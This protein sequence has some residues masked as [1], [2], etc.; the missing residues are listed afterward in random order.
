MKLFKKITAALCAAAMTTALIPTT[1]LPAVAADTMTK[2]EILEKMGIGWNLGNT[3]D[4]SD[5]TWLSNE[6]DYETAWLINDESEK[7]LKRTSKELIKFVHE[8]GFSSIRIPVSWHNHMSGSDYTIN[9]KWMARVHEVVDLAIDEGMFVII[10]IHHDNTKNSN[11]KFFYPS[12]EYRTQSLNYVGDVW[13]QIAKEFKDY[14]QHLIFETLNEPRLTGNTYEWWF[15]VNYPPAE[16]KTAVS[17]INALNQKAVDTI[18]NTGGNN[19]N[20]LIMCPGYDASLDGAIV[21]GFSMPSDS[22]NMTAVSVHSYIPYD[23]AGNE[24]AG[25]EYSDDIKKQLNDYFSSL[26]TNLLDKGYSVVMGEFGAIDKQNTSDRCEW[27]TDFT[28]KT[29]ELGIPCFVWDNDGYSTS[30]SDCADKYG[31]LERSTLTVHNQIY[32][33]ALTQYYPQECEHEW[34]EGSVGS[35]ATL[36]EEGFMVYTC[37]KCGD[38]KK[39][40]IAKLININDAEVTGIEKAYYYTGENIIPLPTVKYGGKELTFNKDYELVYFYCNEKGTAVCEINGK[41][42]Y[43]GQKKVTYEIT[44]RIAG[45]VDGNGV[46][47]MSDLTRLQ[48]YLAAWGVE[49]NEANADLDGKS[50]IAMGDLTRLQQYLAQWDVELV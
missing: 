13:A 43:G 46:I 3:F 25:G 50:G 26:K 15:N 47:N 4:A 28:K 31:L 24:N 49:I 34:D 42:I 12:E 11:G 16:V 33:E 36:Y 27:A 40:T 48:Q 9:E 8:S 2:A 32:L 30:T 37:T 14:D 41:G 22:S 21:S 35:P 23:F 6:L 18:R 29:S 44:D 7:E 17:V 39:E 1:T 45:D 5:C 19:T 38:T 10:N 20:R